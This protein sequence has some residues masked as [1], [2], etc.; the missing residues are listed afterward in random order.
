MTISDVPCTCSPPT[1]HTDLSH[2]KQRIN[3]Q[4]FSDAPCRRES[5]V[6]NHTDAR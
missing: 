1:D 6:T 2:Q 5:F 3:T 4:V